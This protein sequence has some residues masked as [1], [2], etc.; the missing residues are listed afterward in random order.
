MTETT[1]KKTMVCPRCGVRIVVYRETLGVKYGERIN[2]FTAPCSW[3]V[4]D[5][6]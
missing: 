2:Y 4:P 1:T 6:Q 3:H 5:D